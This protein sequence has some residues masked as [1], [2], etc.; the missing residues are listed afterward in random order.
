M[1]TLALKFINS[2]YLEKR[3]RALIEIKELAERIDGGSRVDLMKMRPQISKET[4]I[5]W[6]HTNQILE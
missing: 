2:Q 4:L 3:V 5:E 1:L 6:I